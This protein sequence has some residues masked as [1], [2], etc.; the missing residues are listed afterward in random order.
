M[1]PS[2]RASQPDLL[3]TTSTMDAKLAKKL[4]DAARSVVSESM[5]SGAFDRNELTMGEARRL[6]ALMLGLEEDA[7]DGAKDIRKQVKEA[8]TEAIVSF[9][10][11]RLEL[12]RRILTPRTRMRVTSRSHRARRRRARPRVYPT[13][14]ALRHPFLKSQRRIPRAGRLLSPMRKKKSMW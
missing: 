2:F 9:S 11:A 8:I 7:L 13:F 5:R 10:R 3:F 12:T 6:V 1:V 14:R 4:P